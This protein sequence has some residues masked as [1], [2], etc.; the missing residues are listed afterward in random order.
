MSPHLD[1]LS[2]FR[3]KQSLLFLLSAACLAEK[4]QINSIH[5]YGPFIVIVIKINIDNLNNSNKS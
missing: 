1:T 4:Q 2:W 3:A 5:G